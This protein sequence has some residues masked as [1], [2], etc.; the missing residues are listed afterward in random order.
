MPTDL[1]P[2]TLTVLVRQSKPAGAKNENRP[3]SARP[4]QSILKNGDRPLKYRPRL[5]TFLQQFRA[6]HEDFNDA[7]PV[8]CFREN[9][10]QLLE[11]LAALA[12]NLLQLIAQSRIGR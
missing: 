8:R 9:A 6:L 1:A 11:R 5:R 10:L 7:P 2:F 4:V 3:S 12:D